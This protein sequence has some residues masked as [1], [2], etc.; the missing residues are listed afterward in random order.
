MTNNHVVEKNASTI[1][2]KIDSN[3][4]VDGQLLGNQDTVR[5]LAVIK[6]DSSAV[7]GITPLTWGISENVK[8]GQMAIAIGAP[9]GL[10]GR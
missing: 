8:I 5:D 9:Y 6:V 7:A 1:K 4:T 3:D 2:V 10:D